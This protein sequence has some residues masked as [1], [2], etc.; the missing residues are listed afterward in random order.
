MLSRM[1]YS[2]RRVRAE[3]W[4]AVRATRLASLRDPAAHLAFLETFENAS[5]QPDEFWKQRAENAA[6]GGGVCQQVVIGPDG[7]WVGSVTGLLEQQGELDFEGNPITQRQVHVVGV[8]LHPDHRGRG[9]VQRGIEAVVDWARE[10]GV[11]RV[12][13]N[14]HADNP[15]AQAA[16]AKAGFTPSGSEHLG[17]IG[18]EIEMVRDLD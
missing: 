16:Y 15:R 7:T 11:R 1:P 13:L 3:E 14:V 4:E 18:P 12:R 8:W 5:A 17:A 6:V 9:L 10:Q 2:V